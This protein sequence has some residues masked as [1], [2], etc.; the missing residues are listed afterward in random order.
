[1][2]VE[3]AAQRLERIPRLLLE[4]AVPAAGQVL[5]VIGRPL[6]EHLADAGA[7][8]L[9]VVRADLAAALE[10]AFD[11]GPFIDEEHHDVNRRLTEM[12]AERR[13]GEF[14]PRG[15]H[16]IDE[17]LQALHLHLGPREAV[18]D[19]AIAVFR[20]EETA[21]KDADHLAI[22]HHEAG[23]LVAPGVG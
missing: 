11:R 18:Q 20:L 13:G 12:E 5:V 14:A 22:A 3:E 2:V 15:L 6:L 16:A 1:M 7:P 10:L 17:Q 19:A 8:R 4:D 21:E 23:I 9:L